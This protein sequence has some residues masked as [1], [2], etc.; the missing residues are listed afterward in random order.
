[1]QALLSEI[2]YVSNLWNFI[3][4][5]WSLL[6]HFKDTYT[7]TTPCE[8]DRFGPIMYIRDQGTEYDQI[9]TIPHFYENEFADEKNW[10][11][12]A[13]KAMMK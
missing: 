13:R 11:L 8:N 7:H 12:K 2:Y 9:S 4:S 10:P 1:M 5:H 6:Y 3:S